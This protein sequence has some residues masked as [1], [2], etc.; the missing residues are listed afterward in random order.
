MSYSDEKMQNHELNFWINSYKPPFFH[1]NFYEDFYDFKKLIGKKVVDIGCGGAPISDYCGIDGMDLTI[2]DPL[3][4]KLI[5]SDKY[6]H[7]KKYDYFSGS[8]FDFNNINYDCVVCLNVID[9]FNDPDYKVIDKFYDILSNESELWLYYDLRTKDDGDHL[10]ID[11]EKIMKK[12]ENKF[13]IIKL[14]DSVNPNHK[15]WSSVYKS[16]RLIGKKK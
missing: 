16:I 9:H 13:D 14:S 5:E 10:M 3:M 7:L 12:I 8:L 15:G 2:V 6:K 1:K 4:D 11:E